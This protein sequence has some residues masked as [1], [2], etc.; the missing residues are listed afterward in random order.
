MYWFPWASEVPCRNFKVPTEYWYFEDIC[1]I[2]NKDDIEALV[3]GCDLRDYSFISDMKNLRQLYIYT[4]N[5]I[6]DLS[7]IN[8]LILLRQ[9][10]VVGTY[11]KSFHPI[12]ELL[13]QKKLKYEQSPELES[14]LLY[15][16]EGI[17]IE[18]ESCDIDAKEL[19]EPNICSGEII[20]NG[21]RWLLKIPRKV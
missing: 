17:C 11:I 19:Y 16:L 2:D 6:T 4:G 21:H 10:C 3:I 8:G 18:S 9:L 14:L 1:N 5:N 20:I 7:F 12:K 13:E 15:G